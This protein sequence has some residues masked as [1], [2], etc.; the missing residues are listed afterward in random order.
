MPP[1]SFSKLFMEKIICFTLIFIVTI[2]ACKKTNLE[3]YYNQATI[4]GEEWDWAK[5]KSQYHYNGR[6]G[7]FI[8]NLEKLNQYNES[9]ENIIFN[10]IKTSITK[11]TIFLKS[12]KLGTSSDFPEIPS[13]NFYLNGADG[14]VIIGGYILLEEQNFPS[15]LILEKINNKV[16]KGNFQIAFINA[17]DIPAATRPDTIRFTKGEFLARYRD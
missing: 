8:F 13:A 10:N 2:I 16:I 14:D 3:L 5:Q 12:L 9:R 1:F 17:S 6:T 15:W 4:N 7:D 11:D